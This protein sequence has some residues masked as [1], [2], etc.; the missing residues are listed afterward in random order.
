MATIILRI[1]A[2]APVSAVN[3]TIY[4]AMANA[5]ADRAYTLPNPISVRLDGYPGE[6]FEYWFYLKS[7]GQ[8]SRLAMHTFKNDERTVTVGFSRFGERR[9]CHFVNLVA[10][11]SYAG[12]L[13]ES[14]RKELSPQTRLSTAK[15]RP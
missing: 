3:S 2:D 15:D 7:F 9:D 14:G 11:H 12:W 6:D 13:C 8:E 1:P 4:S 5:I 10:C